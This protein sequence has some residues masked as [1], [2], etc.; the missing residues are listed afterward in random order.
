MPI[1]ISGSN[2]I[3]GVD[4]TA[5]APAVQ[6]ADNNTGMFFPAVD[7]IAFSEG[8]V[9]AL[10]LNSSGN[11]VFTGTIQVAGITT[12][13]YPLVQGTAVAST[14]GT[15]ID[16]TGIPSWARRITV[17]LNGVSTNGT[18]NGLIQLGTSGGVVATGYAGAGAFGP[19]YSASNYTTGFGMPIFSAATVVVEGAVTITNLTGNIW[20]AAGTMSR[21]DGAVSGTTAGRVTLGAVLDRVRLTTV[22][23]TDVFDAGSVNILWE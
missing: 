7:T 1:I 3:S 8:G 2:G 20:V 5:A 19:A 9:E 6:G 15:A 21:S 10:R 4:G 14:S 23:G 17:M 13:L 16:F 22:A 12:S 18:S 11:A